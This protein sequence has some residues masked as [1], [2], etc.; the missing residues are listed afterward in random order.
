VD[1]ANWQYYVGG[2]IQFNCETNLNHAVQVRKIYFD[3]LFPFFAFIIYY[4]EFFSIYF[5][6]S[7]FISLDIQIVGYDKTGDTPH[8]IVR[9]SWG[10]KF[11]DN[12]YLYVA[13]GSNLCGIA[14]HVAWLSVT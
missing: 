8:Y 13:I 3:F 14:N 5:T 2:I 12:G 11:G 7:L 1:A 9:N 6:L 4:I 10:T